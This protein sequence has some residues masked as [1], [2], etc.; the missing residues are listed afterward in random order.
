MHRKDLEELLRKELNWKDSGL[1]TAVINTVFTKVGRG[2]YLFPTDPIYI[3]KIQ[4]AFDLRTKT[5]KNWEAEKVSKLNQPIKEAIK[6]LKDN[7][8]KVIKETFDLKEALENPT[9]PVSD[10][11]VKEEF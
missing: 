4:N 2:Q 7:G 9:R 6:L 1:T 10:F 8:F 11:I 3:G 5:R